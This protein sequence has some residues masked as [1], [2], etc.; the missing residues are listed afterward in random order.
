MAG[1]HITITVDDAQVQAHLNRLGQPGT[2]D[3]MP[4]LGEYPRSRRG[5]HLACGLPPLPPGLSPLARGN[6]RCSI[7]VPSALGSI[8]ARAGEPVSRPH[9]GAGT[10]VYP[11]SR[12][13]TGPVRCF[14]LL[15]AGLSPLARGNHPATRPRA[16]PTG[17]IPARAGEPNPT[18]A[19]RALVGVYP[20]SR[21]GTAE[22][23]VS[24]YVLQ[25]LSPLARGNRLVN[26]A[27]GYEAGSI[28][29]RA[30]EPMRGSSSSA[31]S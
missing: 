27:D 15:Q 9:S 23:K 30:G 7:S 3:L 13:G 11:R 25:G 29:A 31:P 1:I 24:A 22:K 6:Q 10:G 5:T 16:L 8:P 4:R 26:L 18:W 28:P 20:R 19:M 14:E 21:G 12:G 2:G 17:S